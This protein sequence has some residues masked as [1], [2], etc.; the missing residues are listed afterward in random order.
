MHPT[1]EALWKTLSDATAGMSPEQM[2]RPPAEGKWCAAEVVEHLLMSYTATTKGLRVALAKGHPI[3]SRPTVQQRVR[4]FVVLDAGYFPEGRQAPAMVV[5]Q[6]LA[7]EQVM[8]AVEQAVPDMDKAIRECEEK[9]GGKVKIADHPVLG[10]LT[11]EQWR[12]FHLVHARHHAKQ[13]ARIR[14]AG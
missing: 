9:F 10:P 14:Q 12:K 4:Q 5:P 7:A 2:M 1:L 3:G 13:I 11:A 8:R 6:G